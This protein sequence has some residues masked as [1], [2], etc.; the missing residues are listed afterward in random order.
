M[1]KYHHVT[2]DEIQRRADSV[3]RLIYTDV[4][5][6]NK[7]APSIIGV[8]RGGIV[9]AVM[10]TEALRRYGLRETKLV[11]NYAAATHVVDDILDSGKTRDRVVQAWP[12]RPFHVLFNAQEHDGW[13]VFPWE[14][15]VESSTDDI[16]TRLLQFVG[17][18]ATRG[19]LLETPGRAAKA[20]QKW[21]SGYG[22]DPADVLKVFED[23]GEDYN[24]MVMVRNIPV[25]SHCEH[26]LAAI[27]GKASV[28]YIPNGKIVGLSKLNRVVEIF[29]RRLQVQERLTQ[30]IA[31]ALNTNLEPKGVAVRLECRHMCMESRGVCQQGHSTITTALHGVFQDDP[32]AKKEFLDAAIS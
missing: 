15:T 6:H 7:P 31:D 32:S 23:G 5:V 26:H 2:L 10:V 20:W 11:D 22:Q 8:P 28:A 16:F 14:G 13:L 12:G 27:F 24:Q 3:A 29:A 4:R 30:Q 18:D 17:E 9:P 19:G 25:Y 1:D 21:T